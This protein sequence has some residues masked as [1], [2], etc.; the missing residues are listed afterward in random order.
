MNRP[1]VTNYFVN[2][3][4]TALQAPEWE[5]LLQRSIFPTRS[6]RDMLILFILYRIG[7]D[8]M[9]SLLTETSI[10]ISLP[11]QCLCQMTGVPIIFTAPDPHTSETVQ[12]D[13]VISKRAF[14]YVE[15]PEGQRPVKRQKSSN[16]VEP[17]SHVTK[18]ELYVSCHTR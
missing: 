12:S 8:A 17:A 9:L 3:I 14:P 10:F 15:Q 6:T 16:V 7:V 11:N 4:V 1:G 2:T 13:P 18:M 5:T